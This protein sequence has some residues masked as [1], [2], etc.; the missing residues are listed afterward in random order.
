M[1]AE[2]LARL[3]VGVSKAHDLDRNGGQP[4]TCYLC[5]LQ[6]PYIIPGLVPTCF[7]NLHISFGILL[8]PTRFLK[9]VPMHFSCLTKKLCIQSNFFKFSLI[10]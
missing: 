6:F 8:E 9:M 2:N 10:T 4:S 7:T 3:Y 1:G 5:T